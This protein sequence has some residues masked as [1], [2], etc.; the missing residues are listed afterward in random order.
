MFTTDNQTEME[1]LLKIFSGETRRLYGDYA[2]SAGY[3]ESMIVQML[4]HLPKRV[5]KA[6]I[7]DV[8]RAA[9]KIK[10]RLI[11]EQSKNRTFERV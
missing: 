4:P 9:V 6:F 10:A 2:F 5:Q 3:Y 1:N 11:Q 7:G 8:E